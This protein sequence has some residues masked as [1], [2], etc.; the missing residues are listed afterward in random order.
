MALGCLLVAS[1]TT[2]PDGTQSVNKTAV[3]GAIGAVAGGI[4]GNRLDK[5]GSRT[6]GTIAG[7][8]AGA[9]VGGGVGYLFDKQ[10]KEFEQELASERANNE[11]EIE[12]VRDDLLKLTL[13]SEVSF[14][15]DSAAIKPAFQPSLTKLANVLAKYDRNQ[16]TIVGHTD[17]TGSDAYNQGLSVRRAEAVVSELANREGC[18]A[19]CC[20]PRSVGESQPRADNGT[21][22]GRPAQP[23]GGNSDP[24][25]TLDGLTPHGEGSVT[26]SLPGL[27]AHAAMSGR[28]VRRHSRRREKAVVK[29]SSIA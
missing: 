5:K 20:A 24:A 16:V 14:D 12:R 26:G 6:G 3:G 9:A 29:G 18:R 13:D 1:C 25:R 11:I 21:E 19:T 23:P 2:N 4:I 15:Y 28:H 22:A 8:V 10:E 17:S 27:H 7:A